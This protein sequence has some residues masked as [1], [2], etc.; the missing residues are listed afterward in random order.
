MLKSPKKSLGQL[1]ITKW[2]EGNNYRRENPEYRNLPSHPTL[3]VYQFKEKKAVGCQLSIIS[4]GAKD[5]NP[6]KPSIEER[7]PLKGR[8]GGFCSGLF[9][10]LSP[11]TLIFL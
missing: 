2:R 1:R 7:P 6:A 11:P 8:K 9:L 4:S 10:T 5:K 3:K